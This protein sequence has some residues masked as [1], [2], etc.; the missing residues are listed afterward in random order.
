MLL[1]PHR[2]FPFKSTT[3]VPPSPVLLTVFLHRAPLEKDQI[4]LKFHSFTAKH[5]EYRVSSDKPGRRLTQSEPQWLTGLSRLLLHLPLLPSFLLMAKWL[6]LLLPAPLLTPQ[7]VATAWAAP[8]PVWAHKGSPERAWTVRGGLSLP[9]GVFLCRLCVSQAR[10]GPS[11]AMKATTQ[12][13]GTQG[14]LLFS[15]TGSEL[16]NQRFS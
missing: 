3:L 7:A 2:S 6:T 15:E 16:G 14:C 9:P 10:D 13:Q 1:S 12:Q 11:M 8:L 5:E 4:G